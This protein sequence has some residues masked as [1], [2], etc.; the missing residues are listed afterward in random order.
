MQMELI[1]CN[2]IHDKIV[3]QYRLFRCAVGLLLQSVLNPSLC[4]LAI[5]MDNH[6]P[7]LR[8]ATIRGLCLTSPY[9]SPHCRHITMTNFTVLYHRRAHLRIAIA[10]LY[11][12]H[13]ITVS[14]P[15][16]PLPKRTRLHLTI[17]LPYTTSPY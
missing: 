12:T 14:N 17:A 3:Q 2:Y 1:Y 7:P 11:T 4:D 10:L 9:L 16:L 8:D 15:A 13:R 5:A 6:T